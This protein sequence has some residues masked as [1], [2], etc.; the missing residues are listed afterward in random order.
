[1]YK[2]KKANLKNCFFDYSVFHC[3]TETIIVLTSL[4]TKSEAM[5]RRLECVNLRMIIGLWEIS[6]F[7]FVQQ[8]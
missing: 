7:S 5:I 8:R 1:M 4:K 6:T 2:F 3:I